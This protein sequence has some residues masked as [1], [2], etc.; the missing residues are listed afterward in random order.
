MV[1]EG[2]HLKGVLLD[3]KEGVGRAA[4]LPE[5][6]GENPLTLPF[7]AFLGSCPLPN[8][9]NQLCSILSLSA[10]T[11]IPPS[12]SVSRAFL[13]LFYTDACDYSGPTWIMQAPLISA[14]EDP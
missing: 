2:R 8:P 1:L 7:P 4:P 10:F 3:Q 5:A 14:P 11:F 13:F 6:L 9:Q 12:L